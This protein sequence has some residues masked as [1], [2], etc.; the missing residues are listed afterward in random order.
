MDAFQNVADP[1]VAAP[2]NGK[3]EA[4]VDLSADEMMR[5]RAVKCRSPTAFAHEAPIHHLV[6]RIE[7]VP[8]GPTTNFTRRLDVELISDDRCDLD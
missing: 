7:D 4:P 1:A 5:E 3:R 6:E 2:A 8:L